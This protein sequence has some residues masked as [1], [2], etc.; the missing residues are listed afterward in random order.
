MVQIS[1]IVPAFN[2]EER[3]AHTLKAIRSLPFSL[4]LIVVD[5]GSDDNTFS[6]A[7]RYADEVIQLKENQGKG[8]ALEAGFHKGKGEYI[9]CLDADLGSTAKEAEALIQPALL[10]EAD[11]IV[12]KVAPGKK[13]GFGLVKKRAQ[14]LIFEK[15]GVKLEA[16]LSGQRIFHRQWLPCIQSIHSARFGVETEM[17]IRFLEAG[18]KILEIE[19]KMQHREMGKSIKGLWHR[20][21]QLLDIERYRKEV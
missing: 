17:S 20:C 8:R 15:T 10:A 16:P 18:A 13:A 3:I 6:I 21:K 4:E 2:E 12:S 5:D 19:T 7:N 1:V 11:V 14:A 9:L